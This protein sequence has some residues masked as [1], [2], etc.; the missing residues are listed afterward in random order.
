MERNEL[1]S[2]MKNIE[3]Q[4]HSSILGGMQKNYEELE[5]MGYITINWEHHPLSAV[6]TNKGKAFVDTLYAE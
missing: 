6:I 3:H 5:S 4:E 1:E 2:L